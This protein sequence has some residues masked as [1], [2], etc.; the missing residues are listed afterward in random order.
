M[1]P[2]PA[3]GKR[4]LPRLADNERALQ[5]A[6]KQFNQGATRPQTL[7]P[8]A[9][10]LLDNFY[11]VQEQ[12]REIKQ[13]LSNGYYHELPKVANAYGAG[14]PRVYG[15]ALELIA[16]TDSHLDA[17]SVARFVTAYQSVA[18]LTL[19]ELWAVAIMLSLGLVENLRRLVE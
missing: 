3:V 11:I 12:L 10:W 4:L 2:A 15:I 9:E 18:P 7:S 13:D 8:A 1:V 14:Y 6:R 5:A 17:E 19:G 16:H